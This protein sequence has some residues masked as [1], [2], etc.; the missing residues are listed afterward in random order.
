VIVSHRERRITVHTRD[1]N[2][3]W[4][5]RTAIAGGDV[6]FTVAGG[7]VELSVDSIYRGSSIR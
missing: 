3:R 1:D 2:D 5:A 6:T 4:T 7:D